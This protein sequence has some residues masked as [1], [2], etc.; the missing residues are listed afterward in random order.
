MI[1]TTKSKPRSVQTKLIDRALNL[2][3][4]Q[5]DFSEELKLHIVFDKSISHAGDC[6]VDLEESFATLTINKN[7]DLDDMF[8]TLFHELTHVHQIC[9]GHL[10]QSHSSSNCTWKGKKYSHLQYEDFPWEVE[11]RQKENEMFKK[12]IEGEQE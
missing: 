9:N 11:A 3:Q 8:I 1:Y 4:E 10:K 12:F 5:F 7:L 2:A 6:I